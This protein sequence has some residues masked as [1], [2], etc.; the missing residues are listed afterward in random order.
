MNLTKLL[1]ANRGEIAV[2]TM[3]TA[4]TLGISTVAVAPSDDLEAGHTDRADEFVKLEG[5]GPAAYLDVGQIVAIAVSTGC[6]AVHPGYGFLSENVEFA[7][8]CAEAGLNFVGPTPDT[9]RVF[10]DKTAARSVAKGLSVPMLRGTTGATSLSEAEQFLADLGE[11]ATVMVKAMAGG[12]GRGMTPVTDSAMLA[13]AYERCSS[14]ASSAFGKGDL[15]VE[16]LLQRARHIEVQIIGDGTGAVSHLWDRDCSIQRRRQKVVELAPAELPELVKSQILDQAVLIGQSV[17]YRGLGT[18]EFL[19]EGERIAFLEVNPRIQVEHTVTE[20]ML[21]LDLVELQLRIAAGA[22]LSDLGIT[23]AEVP[24]PSRSA[25][26]L[27]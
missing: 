2:R 12:G 21:G 25:C 14:E 7:E 13:S 27:E 19:V 11:G 24:V 23:Q 26:S 5:S 16:E 18:V 22:T 4:A 8:A 17:S 10:G 20:E 3:Q 6:D 1:V 15:Y 9:L